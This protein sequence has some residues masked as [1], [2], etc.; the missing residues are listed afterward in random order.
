MPQQPALFNAFDTLQSFCRIQGVMKPSSDS[1][2]EFEVWLPLS[3][4]NEKYQGIGN[5]GFA[6]YIDYNN[7]GDAVA[8]GY[9]TSST[10][11]GHQATGTDARWALGHPEKIIDYGYRGIHE[12]AVAAK[13]IIQAFYGKM[14]QYSYFN[15]CSNGGRQALMEAQRFPEDYDGIIAG[16][17][18][19]FLTRIGALMAWSLHAT[20]A[21]ED[22]YIAAD[23]LPAIQDAVLATCDMLDGV[24][25]GII[26]D[27]TKCQFDSSKLSCAVM[28]SDHCL[29]NQQLTA[30]EKIYNGPRNE[31][32]DPLFA[33][34][35]PGGEGE[36]D[37]WGPWITGKD[38]SSQSLFFAFGTQVYQNMVYGNPSWDFKTFDWDR[39]FK[40]SQDKLV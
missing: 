31:Q 7:M 5:G 38:S 24:K 22:S 21:S 6:G 33:G 27:P 28:E 19:N 14:P 10:D 20:S 39:D 37:G 1:H 36:P 34:Y 4:W 9:A 12:T 13:S 23:K 29:T 3:G 17:P 40:A 32:G 8:N 16:A 26:E 2:I 11:T 18:A 30:L 15:S 25:D 35:S